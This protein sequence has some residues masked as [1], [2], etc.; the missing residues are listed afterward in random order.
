MKVR[1]LRFVFLSL[2][3]AKLKL[4]SGKSQGILKSGVWQTFDLQGLERCCQFGPRLLVP[5][6]PIRW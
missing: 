3:S 1:P 5:I 6:V 4:A 2:R